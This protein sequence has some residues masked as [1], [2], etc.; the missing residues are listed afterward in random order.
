MVNLV[1]FVTSAPVMNRHITIMSGQIVYLT[2]EVKTTG[3]TPVAEEEAV[4]M[5]EEAV[6]MAEEEDI[7]TA[8]TTTPKEDV[9]TPIITKGM[10]TIKPRVTIMM[11][12]RT[13]LVPI[14]TAI[15]KAVQ[16]IRVRMAATNNTSSWTIT[17]TM[18]G[19]HIMVRSI[20][21]HD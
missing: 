20:R 2:R 16:T 21:V 17:I 4:A 13:I 12:L 14:L 11:K 1:V 10:D 8:L 5:V 18:S 19:E 7:T 15:Q 3:V 9:L 6:A